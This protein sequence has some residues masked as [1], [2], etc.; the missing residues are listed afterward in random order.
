MS[1]RDKHE[2]ILRIENSLKEKGLQELYLLNTL[3]LTEPFRDN[4]YSV[5]EICIDNLESTR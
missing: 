5:D 2:A 3:Y 1:E 4:P